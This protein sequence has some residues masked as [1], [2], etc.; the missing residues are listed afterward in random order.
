MG[1]SY[2]SL[3]G[4]YDSLWQQARVNANRATAIDQVVNSIVANKTRYQTVQAATGVPWYVIGAIHNMEC[5]LSFTKHLHNG[6]PLTGKTYHVPRGRPATGSPPFSWEASATDA[7]MEKVKG[8]WKSTPGWSISETLFKV[9][10]YNGW[11]YR[12]NHSEVKSPY[13]WSGTSNYNR[14]KY[15]ADGTWSSSAVSQQIGIATIMKRMEEKGIITAQGGEGGGV[16]TEGGAY[17]TGCIDPGGAG[18]RVLTGTHNPTS[19]EDALSYALGLH[20]LDRTRSHEFRGVIDI[21]NFPQI[22]QLDAQKKFTIQGFGEGLDGSDWICDEVVFYFGDTAEAEV[23]GYKPDPNAPAPQVFSHNTSE[24]TPTPPGATPD[25][26]VPSGEIQERIFK[27]A[28]ASKGQS[29][30]S[31]PGGGSVACAWCINTL[32]LPKA[33]VKTIGS[34]PNLVDSVEAALQGG[35]GKR[36]EPRTAAGPGDIVIMGKGQRA[37]IG[38]YVGNG[39]TLSNFSSKK[40]FGWEAT[41]EA[42]DRYYDRNHPCRVYRVLN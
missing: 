14:G 22:L 2:G 27:A 41:F 21:A 17:G 9:E 24:A 38:I 5:S 32:V 34:N 19:A 28:Q 12:Q 7:L 39:L 6:D 25:A 26:P 33:G 16:P 3:K 37:H 8:A 4:E 36:I 31:G 13:L 29:S 35:R 15:V 30:R 1:I 18:S 23:L 11:G 10:A 40:Y 42:Y 20:A